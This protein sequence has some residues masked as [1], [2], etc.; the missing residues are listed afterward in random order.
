METREM[1]SFSMNRSSSRRLPVMSRLVTISDTMRLAFSCVHT[2]A[3]SRG[4]R[5]EGKPRV[6]RRDGWG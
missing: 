4:K 2:H 1:V 6:V 5:I 3:E